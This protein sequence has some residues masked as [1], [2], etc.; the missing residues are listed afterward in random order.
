VLGTGDAVRIVTSFY[1]D[2]TSR[3]YNPFLRCALFTS[4]LILC[5]SWSSDC[6]L[7]GCCS[8]LVP[9]I[10]SDVA[11][12]ISSF[13]LL[14]TS[15]LWSVPLISSFD[16]YS[17][18]R[19]WSLLWSALLISALIC[20]SDRSFDLL[21]T[22]RLW[23]VPLICSFDL[24]SDLC[25][26]LL[27]WFL[28]WSAFLIAPLICSWRYVSDRFLRSAPLICV[29]DCSFDFCSDL[30]LWSLLWSAP[31]SSAL[32]GVSG[33]SLDLFL[34]SLLGFY[35]LPPWNRVLAPRVEDTLSNG[36][37]SS[38]GQVVVRGITSVN[39]RRSDNNYS[40]S[41]CLGISIIR[42]LFVVAGKR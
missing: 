17:D 36:Y 9:L 6:W 15:C 7:L 21:L 24:C 8:N 31:L 41:R 5:L 18:L 4:V 30:R 27:L 33:R 22:L 34:W 12:L 35:S 14:L 1:Y 2:F 28:L 42:S 10:C 38:V 3:H 20:V 25:L 19:F 29:S 37:F 13:D 11:S 40:P 23:S 26:W 39:I 16:L 32:I